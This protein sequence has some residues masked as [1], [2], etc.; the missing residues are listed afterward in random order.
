M[1]GV[2]ASSG[3]TVYYT[4]ELLLEKLGWLA[5]I[6]SDNPD[7]ATRIILQN[8]NPIQANPLKAYSFPVEGNP[9]FQPVIVYV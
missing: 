4:A 1:D 5:E 2:L 3:I 6:Y 9:F 8:V 7:V